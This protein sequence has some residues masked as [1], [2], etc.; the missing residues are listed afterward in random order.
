MTNFF[1]KYTQNMYNVW[2]DS[3][4]NRGENLIVQKHIYSEDI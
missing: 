4:L 3:K 2:M 1:V